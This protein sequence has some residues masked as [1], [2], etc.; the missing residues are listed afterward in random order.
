M[1]LPPLWTPEEIKALRKSQHLTQQAIANAIGT[2]LTAWSKWEGGRGKPSRIARTLMS[3]LARGGKLNVK[4]TEWT[5]GEIKTLRQS[6]GMT[7]QEIAS[8]MGV[9]LLAYCQWERAEK[10]PSNMVCVL[11]NVLN[12]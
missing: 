2:S 9:S 8:A 6:L 11:L 4:K 1:T 3:I 12:R 5:G 10:R 7:Q